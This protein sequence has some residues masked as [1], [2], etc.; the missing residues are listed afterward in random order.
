MASP[1]V[2]SLEESKNKFF[3]FFSLRAHSKVVLRGIRIA[4]AGVRF[5]LGPHKF[6]SLKN[7]LDASRLLLRF[8]QIQKGFFEIHNERSRGKAAVLQM[9]FVLRSPAQEPMAAMYKIVGANL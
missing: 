4:E 1:T 3:A 7:I 2:P 6:I 5:S 8:S 9:E